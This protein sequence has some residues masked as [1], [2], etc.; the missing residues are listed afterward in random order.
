ME[1]MKQASCPSRTGGFSLIVVSVLLTVAALVFASLLPGMEAGDANQKTLNNDKKLERV[2]EAM[3]SF[4]A[5]NGR[6]PCPADGQY[7]EGS[8]YFGVEAANPGYINSTTNPGIAGNCVGGT[9]AAPLGPD[10][11]T[12]YVVGGVIP[13]VTLGL[14]DDYQYDDQGRRFTYVVDIRATENPAA[15]ITNNK[16]ILTA[17][18]TNPHAP[19]CYNLQQNIKLN[20]KTPGIAIENTAGVGSTIIDYTMYAYISHGASGYG[21]WPAQGASTPAGRINSGSTDVDM[22]VNAGVDALGASSTFTYSTTNFTNTRIQKDRVISSLPSGGTDTGFDDLV[23]YRPDTKNTCCLGTACLQTGFR[24]DG[25]TAAGSAGTAVVT[26]DVNGD[27]IPDLIISAPYTTVGSNAQAGSVYVIFGTRLGFPD[28]LPLSSLNGANGFQLNGAGASD[29]TGFS[30]ATGDVNG[31][32]VADIVIGAYGATV[33]ANASAGSVYVVF[34][35]RTGANKGAGTAWSSCPCLLNSTFL[36]GTNGS[37]YDG[38]AA[39]DLVGYSVATGDV[40]GDGCADIIIGAEGATVGG[41]ASA[42]SV[43][44][45]FGQSSGWPS[46]AQ[47]LNAAFLN[48]TNGSEYDG[49]AASDTTGVSLA[50]GDVNGD[51]YADIIIGADGATVGV[52][53]FVGSVYVVFGKASGWPT[54]AQLLN[55]AFLNGTNGSEFDGAYGGS[56]YTGLVLATGDVNGDGYADIITSDRHVVGGAFYVIFGKPSGWPTSAQ[57][58]NATFLNGINGSEFDGTGTVVAGYSAATGDVNGDGIADLILSATGDLGQDGAVYAVFGKNSGWPTSAQSLNAAFLN[59]TNGFELAGGTFN[60][61]TAFN[62]DMFQFSLISDAWALGNHLLAGTSVA[63]GDV[64]GDGVADIVIGAKGAE[65]SSHLTAGSV[66]VYF[67][68]K[69]SA[70]NPWPATSYLLNGL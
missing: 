36:N 32:G 63:T 26:G 55:A 13:T 49:A 60:L 23:Y 66:F 4:M 38:A 12:G 69:T 14:S 50:T 70:R 18:G 30:V 65:T 41:H 20:G 68:H 17:G 24:A 56:T 52:T 45:V 6:R 43:Y 53:A 31:D 2:E 7:A 19:G 54:S 40:N 57:L 44:V 59:G 47:L 10:A 15:A 39:G 1:I 25:I 35:G 11:G 58:L 33:G 9:P 3:R 62:E 27:G 46:S 5:T 8:K 22:Q 51:G 29:D 61:G 34:G 16:A 28:P 64:N 67:G 21:A 42:G 48:G 37:E